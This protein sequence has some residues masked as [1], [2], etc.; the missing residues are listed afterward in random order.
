MR[1]AEGRQVIALFGGEQVADGY[2]GRRSA[3]RFSTRRTRRAALLF[4]VLL[5]GFATAATAITVKRHGAATDGFS[6]G[7]S[8]NF[9]TL[10]GRVGFED[11]IY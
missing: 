2:R 6:Q 1:A 9:L 3:A 4:A 11:A 5:I 10:P 7:V 8:A